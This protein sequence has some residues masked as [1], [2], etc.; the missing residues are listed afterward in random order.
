MKHATRL[1]GLML[2]ITLAAC[3]AHL[4]LQYTP[5]RYAKLRNIELL[6]TPPEREY[7]LVA[8]VEGAGGR[9]TA[10]ETMINAMIDEARKL[11]ADALIPLDFGPRELT[12]GE[13]MSRTGASAGLERFVY[14]ENGKTLTRARAIR[15]TDAVR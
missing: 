7:E 8:N 11:G 2:F 12:T 3:H 1:I 15:W 5:D 6:R 14:V 4:E 13:A 9:H 10:T